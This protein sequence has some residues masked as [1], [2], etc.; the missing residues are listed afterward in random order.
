MIDREQMDG[1]DEAPERV[2][3]ANTWG[4][5]RRHLD[6]H[7]E[8]M[9][10]AY[11]EGSFEGQSAQFDMI[12]SEIADAMDYAHEA[13]IREA[14]EAERREER[15]AASCLYVVTCLRRHG[16]RIGYRSR[17]VEAAD[18]DHA[19]GKGLRQMREDEPD[20][21]FMEATVL[22]VEEAAAAIRGDGA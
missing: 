21:A 7:R 1:W 20:G 17:F 8:R 6:R 19:L 2:R 15:E 3:P 12:A 10:M 16:D 22:S 14:V 11:H 18:P 4:V 5:V 13:A 9:R